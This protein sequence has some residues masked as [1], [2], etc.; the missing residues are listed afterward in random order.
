MSPTTNGPSFGKR[1]GVATL[2]GIPGIV[3]L[4][5]YIY[6]TTPP[7]AVPSGLS[8]PFVAL[9][10]AVNPLLLLGV[11]CMLGAYTARG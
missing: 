4:V 7:T 3:A 9:V 8:L 6:L 2:L 11:A 5:G 10:S 1:S